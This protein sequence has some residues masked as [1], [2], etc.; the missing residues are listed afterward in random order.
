MVAGVVK[1]GKSV[2]RDPIVAVGVIREWRWLGIGVHAV[3]DARPVGVV[4]EMGV[5]QT[6]LVEEGSGTVPGVR[7]R[8][9]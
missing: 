1:Q 7:G 5:K 9:L 3:A 6:M 2:A 4:V 8:A